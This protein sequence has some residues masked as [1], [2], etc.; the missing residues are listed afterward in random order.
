MSYFPNARIWNQDK[1][2]L[3]MGVEDNPFLNLKLR[4]KPLFTAP[5]DNSESRDQRP[6]FR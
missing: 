3:T 6:L 2:S 5:A 4:G 1:G